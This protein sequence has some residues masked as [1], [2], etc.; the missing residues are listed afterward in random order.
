MLV[1]APPAARYE[2]A[3]ASV[4]HEEHLLERVSALENRM[5]RLADKLEHGLELLLR[6]ARNSYF[7]RALVETLIGAL[8]E[9]GAVRAVKIEKLWRE[10]CRREDLEQANAARREKLQTEIIAHYRGTRHEQFERE[11]SEGINLLNGKAT[12][13]GIRVLER[14]AAFASENAPLCAFLGEH[15]FKHNK[16][17]L[18][19]DYLARAA[20][21]DASYG[22]TS[23]LLGLVCADLGEKQYAGQLLNSF[24]KIKGESFA[25]R[26]ALGRLFISDE[27]WAEALR[28]FKSALTAKPSPEAHYAL[29]SVYFYLGRDRLAARH[30]RR[31]V[32]IDDEYGAAFYVLGLALLRQGETER[33]H[34]AFS[35]AS[36]TASSDQCYLSLARRMLR[37]AEIPA[38]PKL[39]WGEKEAA[40]R[41]V[42]GG[43]KRL[44]AFLRADALAFGKAEDTF[45]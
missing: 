12:A 41:V 31:A 18:A 22:N 30:L 9:A 36:E 17:I 15:F 28:E 10:R 7:D 8:D 35:V 3:E 6:Q 14:A 32:E 33:A 13:Q 29:G 11:I 4:L 45:I 19:R 37:V 26:Y 1:V 16:L 5:M 27:K 23:L 43:D 39:F 21:A 34:A 25:A 2:A 42:T 20:R 40:K 38:N 24:V 44:A